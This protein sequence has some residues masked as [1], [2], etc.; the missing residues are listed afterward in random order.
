M[1]FNIVQNYV[2]TL[3][4]SMSSKNFTEM[5]KFNQVSTDTIQR[6]LRPTNS[7]HEE[8]L[9]ID[10]EFFKTNSTLYLICDETFSHHPY[11][12]LIEGTDDHFDSKIYKEVRS[13]KTL[14]F[15]VSDG[16]HILPFYS[17]F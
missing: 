11:S 1:F 13:H 3:V 15:G 8:M 6:K 10:Q 7:S 16:K 4:L 17:I 12:K 14:A 9:K 2:K 5:A